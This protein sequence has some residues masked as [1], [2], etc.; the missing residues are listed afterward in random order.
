MRGIG[1]E[2]DVADAERVESPR[3]GQRQ[4]GGLELGSE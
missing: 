4:Q 3:L 2:L 1:I